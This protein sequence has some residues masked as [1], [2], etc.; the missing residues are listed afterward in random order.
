MPFE[1]APG[2]DLKHSPRQ[3][4][5]ATAAPTD[6]AT[7]TTVAAAGGQSTIA[8]RPPWTRGRI[9]AGALLAAAV[10]ATVVGIVTGALAGAPWASNRQDSNQPAGLGSTLWCD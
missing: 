2:C 1:H 7:T 5:P 9:I 8:A 6:E 3:Q 10:T 4:C